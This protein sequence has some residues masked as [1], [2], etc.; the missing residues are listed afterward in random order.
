MRQPLSP[1]C[2][3]YWQSVGLTK[4]SSSYAACRVV[5]CVL[6]LQEQLRS[7]Q[8][9]LSVEQSRLESWQGQLGQQQATIEQL[10]EAA[11]EA[12][13]EAREAAAA[14]MAERDK[15][16]GQHANYKGDDVTCS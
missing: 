11:E 16:R 6:Q 12:L 10:E 4:R 3:P 5:W 13:G 15:V 1:T 14:A 9:Q 2:S 7:D 8:A